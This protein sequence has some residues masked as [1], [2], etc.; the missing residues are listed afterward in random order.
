MI[1][2]P[3]TIQAPKLTPTR[4]HDD[5]AGLDLRTADSIRIPVGGSVE[6]ST[7]D[8]VNRTTTTTTAP[9]CARRTRRHS[10]PRTGRGTP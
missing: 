2:I 4:A 3:M 8:R 1:H 9:D 7:S 5:D 10:Q 6:V